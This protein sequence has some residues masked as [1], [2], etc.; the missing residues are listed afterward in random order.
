[1]HG[2]SSQ[3][4]VLCI[5]LAATWQRTLALISWCLFLDSCPRSRSGRGPS[6]V[7]KIQA[8]SRP[9]GGLLLGGGER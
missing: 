1:M 3:N 4:P 5:V 7:R 2:V 8:G 6:L 9:A